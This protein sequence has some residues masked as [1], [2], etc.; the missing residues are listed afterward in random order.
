MIRLAAD[1]NWHPVFL[2]NDAAA[3]IGTA[4]NPAGVEN[5]AGVISTAFLKDPSDPGWKDDPAIKD[6]LSFM[7]NIIPRETRPAAPPFTATR[8]QKR[9]CR[10]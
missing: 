8:R 5:A 3:S 4:L 7:D 1:L 6:W 9:W 10:C 2:L